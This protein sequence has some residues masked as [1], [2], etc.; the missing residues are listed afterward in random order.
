MRHSARF[1]SLLLFGCLFT[2]SSGTAQ[3]RSGDVS[4]QIQAL[5]W[6][7]GS[8]I[9]RIGTEASIAL[10]PELGFLGSTDTRRFLELNGNPPRDDHYTLAPKSLRWFSVFEFDRS[11]YVRDDEKIDPD[12]LLTILK[13]ANKEGLAE[14]RRLGLPAMILEGWY[15]PPHYDIATKQLEW[16][17][18]LRTEDNGIVVNY[19]TRFLGRNGVMSAILV[20]DPDNLDTDVRAFK[21]A[22]RGFEFNSGAHYS[23]F[24]QGDKVAEYGLA[25]LVVGG[26]AAAAAKA[27]AGKG[28]IKLLG[29]GAAAAFAGIGGFFKRMFSRVSRAA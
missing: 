15:V 10:S 11:G 26:A 8:Q 27:G 1:L 2:A 22:L 23:E 29:V 21:S 6:K 28:L 7:T 4:Q 13:Q 24:R 9:G 16:G 12:E 19:T 5:N 25:A 17:T 14:R 3:D 20:S 18:R